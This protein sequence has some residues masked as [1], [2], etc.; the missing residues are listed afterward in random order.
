MP[1]DRPFPLTGEDTI[2]PD[3]VL[4]TPIH[5]FPSRR[6]RALLVGW[7][8]L[9]GL[10]L[11][12]NLAFWNFDGVWVGVVVITLMGLLALVVGWWVL[13]QWNREVILYE[14]GFSYREGSTNVPF[15]YSEVRAIR[16]R[17]EQLAYFGGLLRRVIYRITLTTHAG[18]AIVLDNTYSGIE[19]LSDKLTEQIN[20]TVRPA[21]QQQ[22]EQG[23]WVAFTDYLAVSRMGIRVSKEV[24]A[25]TD[26]DAVLPWHEYASYR[27]EQRKLRLLT[28]G[29]QVW[30]E[31]PLSEIDNITL[32]VAVLRQR[33]PVI[34]EAT[35]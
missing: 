17:A 15:Q 3:P 1:D 32:L 28:R 10:S 7:S 16:I 6:L 21:L 13:H 4:G 8:F 27:V 11:L 18:E 2:D 26:E 34:K 31:A 22:Y 20:R 19:R 29:G 30:F 14:N 23:E 9:I 33:Q 35:A 12:L 25:D 5:N 24:L